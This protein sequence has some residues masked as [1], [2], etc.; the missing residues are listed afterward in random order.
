[1]QKV[2]VV[3]YTTEDLSIEE[4]TFT[5][6]FDADADDWKT[7]GLGVYLASDKVIDMEVPTSFPMESTFRKT[8]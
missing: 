4:I 1:M 5:E 6:D 2:R 3:H 7:P 8:G